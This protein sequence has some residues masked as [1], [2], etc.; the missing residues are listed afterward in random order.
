MMHLVS[1]DHR[2]VSQSSHFLLRILFRIL[3]CIDSRDPRVSTSI[4]TVSNLGR[5]GPIPRRP[6]AYILEQGQHAGQVWNRPRATC[7]RNLR[8]RNV[9]WIRQTG[10]GHRC[11]LGSQD[12]RREGELAR[13]GAGKCQSKHPHGF[14]FVGPILCAVFMECQCHAQR[15]RLYG[16]GDVQASLRLSLD[17]QLRWGQYYRLH[18]DPSLN[19]FRTDQD[20]QKAYNLQTTNLPLCT[21]SPVILMTRKGSK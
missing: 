6:C 17:Y 12:P 14:V 9:R 11:R 10:H 5:R 16:Q 15:S 1:S 13:E 4:A 7:T 21:L 2:A 18:Y 3:L 8:D 20:A 19:S